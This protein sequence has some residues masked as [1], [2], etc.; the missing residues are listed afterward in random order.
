MCFW[1]EGVELWQFQWACTATGS[2]VWAAAIFAGLTVLLSL[3]WMA[4]GTHGLRARLAGGFI[5]IAVFLLSVAAGMPALRLGGDAPTGGRVVVLLDASESI[6]R[7]GGGDI[8]A[9]RD[10]IA[11]QTLSL[12][13]EIGDGADWRGS[14][15][16]FGA[17]ARRLSPEVELGD[18]GPSVIGGE[19]GAMAQDTNLEAA[20]ET[21]L[22]DIAQGPGAGQII[23]LS[24]GLQTLG[25][26]ASAVDSAQQAGVAIH[27]LA[28]GSDRPAEGLL[29]LN[30]GPD[31]FVGREAVVR[32]TVQGDG[33]LIWGINGEVD[34]AQPD[35]SGSDPTAVRIPLIFGER[36]LNFVTAGFEQGAGNSRPEQLYTLVRG[37]ARVLVFG[38]ASWVDRADRAMFLI[39]RA[40]P[41]DPI[42]L[43]GYDAIVIDGLDPSEFA[44]DMPERLLTAAA[45]GAGLFIVNGP[46][47]G[48]I[49]DMQRLSDWEETVIGPVLPVNSD[50]AQYITEPPKRDILIIIDT[51]GSMG[52]ANYMQL[53]RAAA[54]KVL[55]SLRPQDSI[56][57]LPFSTDALR[58]FRSST[59]GPDTIAD[60]RQ[61]I[62]RLRVAGSTSMGR[63][64]AEARSL[65]GNNCAL[66]I[67]GDGGYEAAQIQ[68]S[69]ICP[70]TAIGVAN[71]LL[72]GIDT[73]WGQ[74]IR[75]SSIGQLGA[76][77]Y[78]AFAPE[79]RT[80]FWADG[81][82]ATLPVRTP[83]DFAMTSNV[84][85]AALSYPRPESHN[86]VVMADAP[87][88]PVLAFRQDPTV[89]SLRT[90]VF[91]GVVPTGLPD[92]PQGW[93]SEV[94]RELIGWDDTGLF[95][96]TFEL[97]DDEVN[98]RL[99]FVGDGPVP[100][101]V[102]ASILLPDGG[103][104]GIALRPDERFGIFEGVGRVSLS[105]TA[106]RAILNVEL[107]RDNVQS[108]PLRL[109][110]RGAAQGQVASV[111]EGFG[112]GVDYD[113]LNDIRMATGGVD[114]MR[115]RP[116]ILRTVAV[117]RQTPIWPF[118]AGIAILIF[119]ASLIL[120]GVRR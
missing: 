58:P 112:F 9:A 42:D 45:S 24:D 16:A 26:V 118:L 98:L 74:G 69:P 32:A 7:T 80:T 10:L 115:S 51:S 68:V 89:R 65:R 78:E 41:N 4:F 85:G 73:S 23:L 111:R 94:L 22:Q 47:R 107:G 1:F 2:A 88:A 44:A 59:S 95:D 14:V 103:S 75:I 79:P 97:R 49:E 82:F 92:G 31:Q 37:P 84:V 70:T 19:L 87:R 90:G 20:I 52:E 109:P 30:L 57:I 54:N 104:S 81:P 114:L 60:A 38:A 21:A 66:F 64:L 120:G 91:L 83:S 8:A 11:Q 72:P 35:I 34:P 55:D 13:Q 53:A 96:I 56:T 43:A 61:F 50:P 106:A 12:A 108:I 100:T 17:V 3:Y 99:V 93:A 36:G 105:N 86:I 27:T 76:I 46:L 67:I 18:L 62:G 116:S 117:P 110:A 28:V 48:A 29:S 102:G 40:A 25:D 39:D 33:R 101:N 71:Q 15:H 6:R 5:V 77:T 63:A 119:A 113:L